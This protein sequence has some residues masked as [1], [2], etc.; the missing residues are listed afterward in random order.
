MK[1]RGYSDCREEDLCSPSGNI[2]HPSNHRWYF[3]FDS[4]K[5][6]AC[7]LSSFQ[8]LEPTALL[9]SE[10]RDLGEEEMKCQTRH[11]PV[12]KLTHAAQS[13]LTAPG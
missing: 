10:G 7:N 12:A 13:E 9:E 2:R 1:P 6:V 8:R 4:D 3:L 11:G 5:A